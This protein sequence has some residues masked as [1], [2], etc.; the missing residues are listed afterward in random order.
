M[1]TQNHGLRRPPTGAPRKID[2]WVLLEVLR[3]RGRS[4]T[5]TCR[6]PIPPTGSMR[7]NRNFVGSSTNQSTVR[8]EGHACFGVERTTA[9]VPLLDATRSDFRH[10]KFFDAVRVISVMGAVPAG[11][12]VADLRALAE[13]FERE[14][15]KR[16]GPGRPHQ[17]RRSAKTG[18][19][20]QPG[21]FGP[22]YLRPA[23][24]RTSWRVGGLRQTIR[25]AACAYAGSRPSR[26]QAGSVRRPGDGGSDEYGRGRQFV[27]PHAR[28]SRRR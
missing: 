2:F 8:L 10:R 1:P 9:A 18:P 17:D 4:P 27:L 20:R 5:A 19:L 24:L 23:A 16:Q 13:R 12:G 11:L 28:S 26:R 7:K 22:L 14:G 6:V 25:H 15:G 3:L 21:G